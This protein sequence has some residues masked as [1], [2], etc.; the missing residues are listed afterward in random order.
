MKIYLFFIFILLGCTEDNYNHIF[1]KLNEINKENI[2]SEV[3]QRGDNSWVFEILFHDKLKDLSWGIEHF[4][5]LDSNFISKEEALINLYKYEYIINIQDS[6]Q[7]IF[8]NVEI[9]KFRE[10]TLLVKNYLLA[11]IDDIKKNIINNKITYYSNKI[12]GSVLYCLNDC[13]LRFLKILDET[14]KKSIFE[15]YRRF[16]IVEINPF[17]Y[18][19]IGS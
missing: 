6:N 4:K 16:N 8:D 11:S 17:W 15:S 19:L 10:D 5:I 12:D 13:D 1:I 18:R 2:Y 9:E 7:I 3:Y 14:K